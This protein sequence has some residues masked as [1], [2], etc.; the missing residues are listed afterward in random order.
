MIILEP[1]QEC[2][3]SAI[4]GFCAIWYLTQTTYLALCFVG[5]HLT[6][7]AVCDYILITIVQVFN[8]FMFN[9]F[10]VLERAVTLLHSTVYCLL[11]LSRNDG[12]TDLFDGLDESG[13]PMENV[14]L[15]IIVGWKNKVL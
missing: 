4:L 7:W 14:S 9:Y 1:S 2:F 11:D 5:W 12:T 13:D 8:A 15:H 3:V 6:Y 10:F